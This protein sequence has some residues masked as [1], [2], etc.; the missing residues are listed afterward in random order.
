MFDQ[1][2]KSSL[3][4]DL[5]ELEAQASFPLKDGGKMG[6]NA[7]PRIL[8]MYREVKAVESFTKD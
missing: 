8:N 5:R 6:K 4:D 1:K 7:L 3:A 2:V